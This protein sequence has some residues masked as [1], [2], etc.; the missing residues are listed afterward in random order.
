MSRSASMSPATTSVGAR[1]QTATSR[2][3]PR[4]WIRLGV[5]LALAAG[6]A[7]VPVAHAASSSPLPAIAQALNSATSYQIDI[8][9]TVSLAIIFSQSKGRFG[10]LP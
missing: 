5:G 8:T 9:Q 6:S 7:A 1:R 3:A 4:R 10:H 2:R